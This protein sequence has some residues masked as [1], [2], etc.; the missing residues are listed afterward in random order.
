MRFTTEFVETISRSDT[1]WRETA[2]SALIA[3][4]LTVGL[5]AVL[6][7]RYRRR[8]RPVLRA[9]RH[10]ERGAAAAVDFI[11]TIPIV[12]AVVFLIIQFAM[13][14]HASLVVHYAAFASA[15][16]ARVWY[17]DFDTAFIDGAV[18][19]AG[20][21]PAL[22]KNQLAGRLLANK[23]DADQKAAYA[24]S[25]ALIPIAPGFYPGQAAS[26]TRLDDNTRRLLSEISK[27]S[28]DSTLVPGQN[29]AVD[30]PSLLQRK[31]AYAFSDR[32][33]EVS[34]FPVNP[35]KP[36]EL[37]DAADA[38]ATTLELFSEGIAWQIQAD[39]QFRYYLAI[40]FASRLFGSY[41]SE[42]FYARFL[43]AEVR[44]L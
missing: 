33:T 6:V 13:L 18:S 19:V 36:E 5:V 4:M 34:V 9:L 17:W 20:L 43:N 30:R 1:F 31:A 7:Y 15:R 35:E 11:L 21:D 40:P 25:L 3:M 26:N 12:L 29:R 10:D 2:V 38:L 16:S 24:A 44:L 8:S 14:A 42:G 39:V 41:Q 32:N 28:D 27:L 23:D 22:I 37:V